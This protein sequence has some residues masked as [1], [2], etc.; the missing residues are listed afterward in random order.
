M[1]IF[2]PIIVFKQ[3]EVDYSVQS[4]NCNKTNIKALIH[5]DSFLVAPFLRNN[6][7]DFLVF[8]LIFGQ[9]LAC[10]LQV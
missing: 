7:A 10:E 4:D 3:Y 6:P 8:G 2:L 9:G 5:Y 1:V